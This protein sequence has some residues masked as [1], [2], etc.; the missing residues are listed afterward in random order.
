MVNRIIVEK[1][2]QPKQFDSGCLSSHLISCIHF[3]SDEQFVCLSRSSSDASSSWG[4]NH[5]F[6]SW[7]CPTWRNWFNET[8]TH[9]I[10]ISVDF[11]WDSVIFYFYVCVDCD[12]HSTSANTRVARVDF[13]RKFDRRGEQQPNYSCT[14]SISLRVVVKYAYVSLPHTC[15]YHI[16]WYANSQ[17]IQLVPYTCTRIH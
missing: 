3:N 5:C 11:Q 13:C 7:R 4:H 16:H 17:H 1:Y 12:V 8:M 2:C 9:S 6:D 14:F 10:P 15:A